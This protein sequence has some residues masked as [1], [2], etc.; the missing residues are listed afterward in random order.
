MWSEVDD[1]RGDMSLLLGGVAEKSPRT[2]QPSTGFSLTEKISHPQT[3]LKRG[4]ELSPFQN[5][6][7]AIA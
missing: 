1:V 5:L 2:P 4:S 6:L 7:P 3:Q